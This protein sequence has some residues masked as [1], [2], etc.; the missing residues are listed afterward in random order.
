MRWTDMTY[1]KFDYW[2]FAEELRP[3]YC[4]KIIDLAEN[5]WIR[6]AILDEK[7]HKNHRVAWTYF[8]NEQWIYDIVFEYMRKANEYADWNFQI[9]ASEALQITKYDT[10]GYQNY[11]YDGDGYT[12]YHRPHEELLH[13]KTRKLSMSIILNDDFEGGQLEFMNNPNPIEDKLGTIVVFPSYMQHRVKPV[14]SGT[15]YSL[16]AWFVGESFR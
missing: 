15:R 3:E 5:K 14:T 6:G 12:R 9:D 7:N 8:T 1:M 10:N 4:K 11:H 13:N 16:V 2:K